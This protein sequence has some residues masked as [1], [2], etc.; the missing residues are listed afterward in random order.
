MTPFLKQVAQAYFEN[1]RDEMMDYCFVFPNKRSGVF[2]RHFL[3]EAAEGKKFIFPEITTIGEMTASFSSLVEAPRIDQLFILYN[4]Y[5]A[6]SSDISD[7]DQFLF[8]GDMLLSDFNDVDRYLVN[9]H[10]LF[11]NLKRFREVSANYLTEEQKEIINRYWGAQYSYQSPDTFWNHLHH[12]ESTELEGKFLKLWEVLD[13]LFENFKK[14]LLDRGMATAGM[15]TRNAVD[16]LKNSP[17]A[18]LPYRRYIFVGFNVLTLSEIKIFERLQARGCADFYWDMAA[19][20]FKAEGNRAALFMKHN[21]ECFR[22][23]YDIA[24]AYPIPDDRFPRIHIT[25][26]PSAV[27]QAKAAGKQLEEWVNDKVIADPDNAINTA[28]VLPDEALFIPMIHAVPPDLTALNVTMGYPMK[29]TSF[30]SF[31]AAIVSMQLRSRL[32][33][34]KWHFFH[35]DVRTVITHPF[36]QSLAHEDCNSILRTINEKRLY[37]VPADIFAELAP[38]LAFIFTPVTDTNG[39]EEVYRYFS[40]LIDS[41]LELTV[42]REEMG[43]ERFFL[44]AYRSALDELKDACDRWGIVMKES[45]FIELLQRTIASVS[46]NFTGEPL[47]GL[48]VMGV[49]ETR[50]LDFDNLIMLSMNERIF[51]RKHYTRSF[52]PDSLRRSYGM[53]TTDFQESIYAYYF[54]RLISRADNVRLYYDARTVGTKNSEMSRYVSQLLYLFPECEITHDIA[55]FRMPSLENEP[56]EIRKTPEI[57]EKLMEFT[58]KGGKTLSASS[59]K[60]YISCPLEFYLNRVCNLQQEDEMVEYMDSSTYGTILHAVAEEIYMELRGGHDEVKITAEILDSIINNPLKIEKLITRF[61]NKEYNKL[62]DGDLTPLIGEAKV[63][64]Q[65]MLHFILV[66][67]RQEKD[68]APFDFI[69]GEQEL[70]GQLRISDDISIN[71][72]QFI[73]R[74]D[75]VYP[76]GRYGAPGSGLLRIV[77][78]KTGGDIGNFTSFDQLFDHNMKSKERRGAIFQLMFYCNAYAQHNSFD[79]PIQPILYLFKT[80]STEGIKPLT[81]GARKEKIEIANYRAIN[82]EFMENFRNLII[83]MFDP[84]VPFRQAPNDDACKF[85]NFKAICRRFPE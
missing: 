14:K 24:T 4:E 25:G 71:F 64:G 78:Y 77:D 54:Y 82:D 75:R 58:R 83:E 38:S 35:D 22:S 49:L 69:E 76:G 10:L 65:V 84:D 42:T 44:H 15:L 32:S 27:G 62:P 70:T 48:Q 37:M 66:M 59:I 60:E 28:V 81:Y 5:R 39:V 80:M 55:T 79:G 26:V 73:D 9:P 33:K 18:E 34:E 68:L 30:A 52:I 41:L 17:T 45:T 46:I 1:E 85:C 74:I 43:V 31:I 6:L 20:T 12:E 53:A 40:T 63:L 19:P 11:V 50:V 36:T 8:W 47:K 23:R 67:L 51:P 56:I 16:Y 21:V 61:I 13:P 7:F 72:R 57:M 3:T 2:F 29:N